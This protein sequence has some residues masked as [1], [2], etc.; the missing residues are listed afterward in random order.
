VKDW[1]REHAFRDLFWQLPEMKD[2]T[3]ITHLYQANKEEEDEGERA[4]PVSSI[5]VDI[6]TT[7]IIPRSPEHSEIS[8]TRIMK[9]PK[10]FLNLRN[11]DE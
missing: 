11:K 6:V 2:N 3:F 1:T 9:R 5:H 4:P 7:K 8:L 10:I